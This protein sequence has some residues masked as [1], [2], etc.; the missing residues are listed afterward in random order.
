MQP[1]IH[2]FDIY[3]V[4]DMLQVVIYMGKGVVLFPFFFTRHFFMF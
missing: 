2:K 4:K 1:Q 3:V